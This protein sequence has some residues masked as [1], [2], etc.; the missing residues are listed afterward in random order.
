MW[1]RGSWRVWRWRWRWRWRV[2]R[3]RW[4]GECFVFMSFIE[5]ML[6]LMTGFCC[7]VWWRRIID[8][9]IVG[10][11]ANG[12]SLEIPPCDWIFSWIDIDKCILLKSRGISNEGYLTFISSLC[13]CRSLARTSRPSPA[14]LFLQTVRSVRMRRMHASPLLHT[15]NSTSRHIIIV[16]SDILWSFSCG[17]RAHFN[18]TNMFS[19]TLTTGLAGPFPDYIDVN[20]S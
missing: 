9:F 11:Y 10:K 1:W 18:R 8:T 13:G 17:F 15:S 4:W 7:L 6:M 14:T 12:T 2:R 5:R 20:P 19:P 3:R 16:L